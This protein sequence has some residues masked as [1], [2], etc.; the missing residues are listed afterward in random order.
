VTIL[1]IVVAR[2]FGILFGVIAGILIGITPTIFVNAHFFKED[3]LLLLGC[4]LV[5]LALQT[6]DARPTRTSA[7]LLGIAV[8]IACSAKYVGALMLIPMIVLIAGKC[9]GRRNALL[10]SASAASI[11]AMV[12]A[13]GIWGA[14]SLLKGLTYELKHVTSSHY[15]VQFGPTSAAPLNFLLRSTAPGLVLLWLGGLLYYCWNVASAQRRKLFRHHF[16]PFEAALYLIPLL[17]LLAIQISMVVLPRY[18]MPVAAMVTL[19][20][21]WTVARLVIDGSPRITA[22]AAVLLVASAAGTIS[23]FA[24]SASIFIDPPRAKIAK[25]ISSNLPPTAKIAADFSS[26]IPDR[27]YAELDPTMPAMPL[28]VKVIIPVYVDTGLSIENLRTAGFTHVVTSGGNY[29]RLFDPAG[30]IVWPA[31]ERRKQY[32]EEVF[33]NLKLLYDQPARTDLDDL[34]DSRIA[35]YD[36]RMIGSLGP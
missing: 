27:W 16:S 35:V 22:V 1:A 15:G 5:L 34:F 7:T 18:L 20:G 11:F 17:F 25:W 23:S 30:K 10:A 33:A 13:A 21:V 4:S 9:S 8:G 14:S 6:F 31:A 28:T 29:D 3:A 26:G 36:L 32:Y 2:R 24:T 19:A 12:N